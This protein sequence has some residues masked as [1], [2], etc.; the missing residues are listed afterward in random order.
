MYHSEKLPSA[1][2]RYVGEIK[3]VAGVLDT[4]LK[5][6]GGWLVGNKCTYADLAFVPW[7]MMLGFLLGGD[8][9][10][11][12]M[13]GNPNFKKWHETMMTRPSVKKIVEYRTSLQKH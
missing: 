7:D 10:K 9:E 5:Q 8:G 11:E 2:D 3:R 12:I 13:D 4:H 6:S 1:I